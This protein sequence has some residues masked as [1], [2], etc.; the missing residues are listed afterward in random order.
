[1]MVEDVCET[2]GKTYIKT[3]A[4][5]KYCQPFCRVAAFYARKMGDP[6]DFLSTIDEASPAQKQDWAQ[7]TE[8]VA[9]ARTAK[10]LEQF[11]KMEDEK[12]PSYI[13][14]AYGVKH[15]AKSLDTDEQKD[16]LEGRSTSA[17]D[18]T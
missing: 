1:M 2:C 16:S 5:Q 18:R 10:V 3:R 11:H 13:D 14:Q 12:K 8:K 7:R 15:D 4:W 6:L 17:P 9:M